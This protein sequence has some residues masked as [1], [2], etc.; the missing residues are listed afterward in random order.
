LANPE[1]QGGA[2]FALFAPANTPIAIID[3]LNKE[4]RD[5]FTLPTSPAAR[6]ARCRPRSRDTEQLATTWWPTTERWKK[7]IREAGIKLE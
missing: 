7:V 6:T 1:I 5:T 2:W 4:G 3:L